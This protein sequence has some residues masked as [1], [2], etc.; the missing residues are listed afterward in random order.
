[1]DGGRIFRSLLA[2]RLG[3]ERATR[4]ASWLAQVM[5]I[6]FFFFAFYHNDIILGLVGVFVFFMASYE[7]KVVKMDSM[8]AGHLVAEI[9][10]GEFTK[11]HP[12]TE[13]SLLIDLLKKGIEKNFL[14]LD[15]EDNK[16]VGVL[17]EEDLLKAIKDKKE[18]ALVE[19]YQSI[20]LGKLKKADT[21][22]IAFRQMQE[23]G[24]NIFPVYEE[25]Q[26]VGV[27]TMRMI[28]NFLS[29][30]EKVGR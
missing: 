8:L 29:I 7:Y 3:K 23:Q 2:I 4:Y 28:T 27:V 19:N 16:V 24:T 17:K 26:L 14:V 5:A 6:G 11:I 1:M 15:P 18:M 10:H 12:S 9:M 20:N 22:Q 13:I 25:D 21:L 30:Q